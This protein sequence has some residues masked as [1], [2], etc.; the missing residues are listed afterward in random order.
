MCVV[1]FLKFLFL[2]IFNYNEVINRNFFSREI[3]RELNGNGKD[4][5]ITKVKNIQINWIQ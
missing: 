1:F 3:Y 5:K 2:D 4:K